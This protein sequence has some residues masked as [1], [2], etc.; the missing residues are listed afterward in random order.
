M[1][2]RV[3]LFAVA[4]CVAF[5]VWSSGRLVADDIECTC[6]ESADTQCADTQREAE[7]SGN[8]LET[9]TCDVYT[10]P[11]FANAQTGLAGQQAIM[12]W[13]IET[14]SRET[15]DLSGLNV[16]LIVRAGETLGFGEAVAVE[17]DS[18]KSVILVDERANDAQFEALTEFV[19]QHAG[20]V[21]GEV[22]RVARVPIEMSVDH[23]AMVGSL[24]AGDE[25][26]VVTRKLTDRDRCCTNEDVFYP[27]LAE[28]GCSEPAFT[29]D[30]GFAGR[31]LGQT[32]S[33][34]RTR[35]AF[36]ATFAY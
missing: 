15:L 22:V 33:N 23:D 1:F 25:A 10:G 11:C 26:R 5:V 28:V 35:S 2:Y 31:G 13:N 19:K 27:P 12:A 7:I 29:V 32:W 24:E 34:P 3:R 14:G 6:T 16:V 9:R 20:R 21:A 30:G 18:I 8:Y 4:S 17:S 36:L